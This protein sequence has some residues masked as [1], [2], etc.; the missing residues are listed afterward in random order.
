MGLFWPAKERDES[1]IPIK[2]GRLIHWGCI[3]VA[4]AMLPGMLSDFIGDWARLRFL[5][6]SLFIALLGRALRFIM[7][8]E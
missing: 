5:L 6:I 7:A 3:V 8:R 1:T 2:F 4:I